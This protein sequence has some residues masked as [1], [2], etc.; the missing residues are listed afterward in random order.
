MISERGAVDVQDVGK[1]FRYG[2]ETPSTLKELALSGRRRR[3]RS[4]GF[5]A[6]RHVSH[7]VDPG[8]TVGLIGRNGSG[9]STLLR[10]IGGIGRPDE[11]RVVIGGRVGALL[12][13]GKEFHPELTGRENAMLSAVVAGMSRRDARRILP[14]VVDFA[15]LG[16]FIDNPLRTYSTGMQA[17]LAFATAVH[18]QPDVLL[19][20]EVLA[21]GDLAFQQRCVERLSR[22]RAE[23]VTIIVVS[24]DM[25]LIRELCDEV[26]WLRRGERAASGPPDDVVRTYVETM[27]SETRAMTPTGPDVPVEGGGVLRLGENRF[28]SQ[29]ARVAHVAIFDG[30]GEPSREVT[31]GSPLRIELVTEVPPSIERCRLVVK[32]RRHDDVLCVDSS[33]DVAPPGRRHRV[34]LGRLDL[35]P[36][37]YVVDVGLFSPDWE[38]T[39]DLHVGVYQ[40]RVTGE[41]VGDALLAPPVSWQ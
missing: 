19:V 31:V 34:V 28:G 30:L 14:S 10:L 40:L 16:P 35:A 2:P 8:R 22:F 17:R 6:L 21:V 38:H 25:R 39:H 41:S 36:G 5:W 12:E 24:H 32:V 1:R 9:K 13:L 33:T 37:D 26:V 3:S 20:D 18:I 15:E 29:A 4:A 11:G 23:G 7:R 27:S